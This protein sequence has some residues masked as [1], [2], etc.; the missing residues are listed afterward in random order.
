MRFRLEKNETPSIVANESAGQRIFSVKGRG[1]LQRVRGRQ[2]ARLVERARAALRRASANTAKGYRYDDQNVGTKPD[3]LDLL[4]DLAEEGWRLY[5]AIFPQQGNPRQGR[6]PPLGRVNGTI[7]VGHIHLDEVVP[8]SLIYDR[9]VDSGRRSSRRTPRTQRRRCTWWSAP[10]VTRQCRWPTAPCRHWP[11]SGSTLYPPR[12]QDQG[13]QSGWTPDRLCRNRYSPSSVLGFRGFM[14]SRFRPSRACRGR[15]LL[16]FNPSSAQRIR[17][18]WWP[19]STDR[20][21]VQVAR[22]C[23]QDR[24]RRLG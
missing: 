19:H 16:E 11:A 18:R 15:R 20:H 12:G 5:S 22:G 21:V 23:G 17:H 7:H 1:F 4:W 8:W 24:C 6:R 2:R 13:A 10:S 14:K 3:L 9:K